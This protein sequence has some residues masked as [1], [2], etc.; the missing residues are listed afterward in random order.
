MRRESFRRKKYPLENSSNFIQSILRS[1]DGCGAATAPSS[2]LNGKLLRNEVICNLVFCVLVR[3]TENK[4]APIHFAWCLNYTSM[5]VLFGVWCVC[6]CAFVYIYINTVHK[7]E[8]NSYKLFFVY[9]LNSSVNRK[10]HI[11]CYL[12]CLFILLC[13]I[14]NRNA[15]IW[16]VANIECTSTLFCVNV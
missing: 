11:S 2:Q 1:D 15:K 8:A 4:I 5:C 9:R 16:V 7:T 10:T 13:L 3:K 12:F 14:K 6:V